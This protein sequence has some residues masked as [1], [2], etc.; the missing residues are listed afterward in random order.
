MQ[1]V[2]AEE[3]GYSLNNEANLT[4]DQSLAVRVYERPAWDEAALIHRCK[5]IPLQLQEE[6]RTQVSLMRA[7]PFKHA[8]FRDTWLAMMPDTGS[9][10][11]RPSLLSWL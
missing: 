1:S 11:S 2:T 4:G 8:L 10:Q 3:K 7:L 9:H 6:K 5:C